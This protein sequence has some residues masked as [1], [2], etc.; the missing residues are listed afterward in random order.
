[1][2]HCDNFQSVGGLCQNIQHRLPSWTFRKL[3]EWLRK[4]RFYVSIGDSCV[5]GKNHMAVMQSSG[6]GEAE[7][8]CMYLLSVACKIG[9]FIS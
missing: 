1:M 2:I 3:S 9:F 7:L 5:C 8:E 6:L 4:W